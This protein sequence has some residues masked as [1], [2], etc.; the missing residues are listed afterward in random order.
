[1]IVIN[2]FN[3]SIWIVDSL[4]KLGCNAATVA[5]PENEVSDSLSI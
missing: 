5:L 4:K 3:L 1:M 2:S